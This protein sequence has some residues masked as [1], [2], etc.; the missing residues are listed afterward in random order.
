MFVSIQEDWAGK[1]KKMKKVKS[2]E[3]CK[4]ARNRENGV[5]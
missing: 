5:F 3:K 4:N 1:Q 2:W